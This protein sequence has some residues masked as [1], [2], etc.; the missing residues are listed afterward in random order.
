MRQIRRD[1][2]LYRETIRKAPEGGEV[3]QY[4]LQQLR[5]SPVLDPV[6]SIID[7]WLKEDESRP[8]KQR[9]TA[10]LIYERSTTEYGFQGAESTV[11]WY[12][13][14]QRK[15]ARPQVFLPQEY[16]PGKVGQV[17]FGQA[18]TLMAR[19][20]V[21][22]QI[23]CLRLGYSKQPFV[24]ALPNQA[25]E[26]FFEGH[27]RAFNFLGAVPREIWYD[28]LK[29]AV[30]GILQGRNREEQETFIALR[31][32]PAVGDVHVDLGGADAG[33]TQPSLA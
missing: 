23:F 4:T 3:P 33:V 6:R 24:T 14:Q 25:Q 21:T 8:V 22:V 31:F 13:G 28:N 27:V 29:I 32:D 30:K 16:E 5:S 9:H 1:T 11:R 7:Q 12:V 19:E 2:G 17:D 10:K 26:A 18:Q 20:K 15:L